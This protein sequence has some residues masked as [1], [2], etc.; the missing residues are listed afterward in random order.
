MD[1]PH[2][3]YETQQAA[4]DAEAV[5][6]PLWKAAKIGRDGPNPAYWANVTCWHEGFQRAT[7]GKW[8]RPVCPDGVEGDVVEE[9]STD[10]EVTNE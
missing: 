8:C 7:D 1:N 5:D 3:I 10:W 9:Y 6:F 2:S 4:L